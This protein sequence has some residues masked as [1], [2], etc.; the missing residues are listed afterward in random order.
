MQTLNFTKQ[1]EKLYESLI[2][3]KWSHFPSNMFCILIKETNYYYGTEQ[4]PE[5][6]PSVDVGVNVHVKN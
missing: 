4:E 6:G 1:M 3:V 2:E 5:A